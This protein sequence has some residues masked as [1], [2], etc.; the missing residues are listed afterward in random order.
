MNLHGYL[1]TVML[2]NPNLA[3]ELKILSS[4]NGGT[5]PEPCA[6]TYSGVARYNLTGNHAWH[7]YYFGKSYKLISYS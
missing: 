2:I 1:L 6:L 3:S 5:C 7:G 4:P